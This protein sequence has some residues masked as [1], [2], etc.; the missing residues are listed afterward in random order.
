MGVG[1]GPPPNPKLVLKLFTDDWFALDNK[2]RLLPTPRTACISKGED[3]LDRLF[4][5]M[6]NSR[7]GAG[8]TGA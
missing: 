3:G 2:A 5:Q 1:G 6:A 8:N 7:A 4:E